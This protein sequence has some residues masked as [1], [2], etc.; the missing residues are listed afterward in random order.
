MV[1]LAACLAPAA[2]AEPENDGKVYMQAAMARTTLSQ[3]LLVGKQEGKQAQK[4]YSDW[5][6]PRKDA[7]K[8]V[9][10]QG[11]GQ[12]CQMLGDPLQPLRKP[13]AM[14]GAFALGPAE[15]E[16]LCRDGMAMVAPAPAATEAS[17]ER[18]P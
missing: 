15:T 4:A 5:L 9:A 6:A 14:P 8:R 10:A 12:V 16:K 17:P 3:C 1:L 7:V 11:C 18:Q 2:A 13:P